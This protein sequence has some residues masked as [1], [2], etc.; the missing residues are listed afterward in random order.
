[1]IDGL[2]RMVDEV[3][4]RAWRGRCENEEDGYRCWRKGTVTRVED[5]LTMCGRCWRAQ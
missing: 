5:E 1:M 4:T 3:M 2:I